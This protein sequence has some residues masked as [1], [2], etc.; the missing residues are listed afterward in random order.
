LVALPSEAGV[1]S[2]RFVFAKLAPEASFL[3]QAVVAGD[4][5]PVYPH[6]D[7][8]IIVSCEPQIVRLTAQVF[9]AL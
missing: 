3:P 7:F 8:S 4:P 5:L 6:F 1:F 2:N 9:S